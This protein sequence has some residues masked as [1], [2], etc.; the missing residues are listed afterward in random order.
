VVR[1]GAVTHAGDHDRD[2]QL[3][4]LQGVA[5]AENGPGRAGFAVALQGDAGEAAGDEGEVV[6]GGPGARPQGAEAADAVAAQLGL[7]LNVFDDGGRVRANR[8]GIERC[9]ELFRSIAETRA[10]ESL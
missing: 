1:Q 3:D 6:E 4:R 7:D 8:L 9:H 2:V 5:G 10:W